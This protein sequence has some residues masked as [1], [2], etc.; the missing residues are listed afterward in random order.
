[1]LQNARNRPK[2]GSGTDTPESEMDKKPCKSPA[3]NASSPSDKNKKKVSDLSWEN[4]GFYSFHILHATLPERRHQIRC[5]ACYM[6]AEDS[7][8]LSAQYYSSIWK[9]GA[10]GFLFF[11]ALSVNP[12]SRGRSK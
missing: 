4:A 12:L 10:S 5:L 6:Y 8:M 9:L 1:M 7:N 11:C 2:R 3:S